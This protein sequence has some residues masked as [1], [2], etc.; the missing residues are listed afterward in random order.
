MKKL[1]PIFS[2]AALFCLNSMAQV[3]TEAGTKDIKPET[4][5]EEPAKSSSKYID[6]YIHF[7]YFSPQM[8]PSRTYLYGPFTSNNNPKYGFFFEKGKYRFFSPNFIF[9]GKSNIGLYSG[10]SIGVETYNFNLPE[11]FSGFALPFFF[12]D[13]KYGPDFRYEISEKVKLDLYGNAGLLVSWGGYIRD[14]DGNSIYTPTIP[15]F[16]FQYGIGTDLS[17][18]AFVFG[19]QLNFAQGKYQYDVQEEFSNDNGPYTETVSE[20]YNVL[21]NSFK[22]H[23]G[24]IFAK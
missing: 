1:F 8:A 15:A 19:A 21:L 18:G 4:R 17:F 13:I 10:T 7:G 22:V 9:K 23:I 12:L 2:L 5:H 11:S 24:F 20:Q 6:K 3:N 16:A 14:G